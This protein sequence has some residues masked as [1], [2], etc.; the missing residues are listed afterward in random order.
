MAEGLHIFIPSCNLLTW[1]LSFCKTTQSHSDDSFHAIIIIDLSK[2]AITLSLS[3]N[4]SWR[5]RK[6]LKLAIYVTGKSNIVTYDSFYGTFSRNCVRI[7]CRLRLHTK[8][9]G[10]WAKLMFK[11]HFCFWFFWLTFIVI[12]H[13]SIISQFVPWCLASCLLTAY[14]S[15]DGKDMKIKPSLC[16]VHT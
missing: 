9:W 7:V 1:N 10:F 12:Y 15:K 13:S 2:G 14:N 16:V 8:T 6:G 11:M 5:I 3:V 4:I